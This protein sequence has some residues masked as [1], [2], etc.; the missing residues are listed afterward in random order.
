MKSLIAW[1]VKN[2]PAMNTVVISVIVV[3][4]LSMA[5]MRR[6]VFPD[7]DLEIILV[8]VP[9]P[10]A[11]P[12]EVEEGICLKVEE[13]VRS[14]EGVKRT[15]AIAQEGSGFVVLEMRPN[16]DVQKA[17]SEVRS[18]ID[19]IPSFPE[20]AEDPEVMQIALRTPAIRVA[21]IAPQTNDPGAD[22]RLRE[23]TER[24][25]NEL[26]LLPS[27]SQANLI[28]ARDYQIDVEIAEANLR[29]YG[30]SLQEVARRIRRENI[31][32]PAGTLKTDAS[33]VLLRGKDKQLKG[34]DIAKIPLVSQPNGAVLNVGDLGIVRDEFIDTTAI[35]RIDG[36][37]GL[38]ISI[39][40]TKS[41]D[42]VSMCNAV[43]KYCLES[44]LPG[45]YQLVAFR[46]TSV[47][48]FDRID[49]LLRNGCQG[50]IIVFIVLAMFME[51]RLAF[52][53]SAGI[54]VSIIGACGVLYFFGDTLN[55][56]SLYGFL[57][58]LGMV[59]DDAI[60]VGENIYARRKSGESPEQASIHGCAEVAPSVFSSVMTTVVCFM[61]LF[62]VSGVMGKFIAVMPLAIIATL[63]ISL[64][65][66]VFVL[67]VHLSEA[68]APPSGLWGWLHQ[69]CDDSLQW[70]I[71]TV[72][73]PMLRWLLAYPAVMICGSL[74]ILVFGLSL[75]TGGITPWNIFPKLDSATIE[76]RITYPDGTSAA[77]T[78]DACERLEA[79]I[80]EI[81]R[82]L[83][84]PGTSMIRLVHRLVGVQAAPGA[85]GPETRTSGAHVGSVTV[86]LLESS[87]RKVRSD[88]LLA[89][90]R[91]KMGQV[92]GADSIIFA[93]P[94]IGPGGKP[95]EF[96]LLAPLEKMKDLEAATEKVKQKL[97]TYK[98]VYDIAD[99]SRP[100]KY[101]F[102]I[103]VKD[104]A[105][106]LGIPLAD[107][108]ETVR[109]SF[110]G[111]EVMRLQ[112]GR[113]EVKLMVRY[114]PRERR[115]PA[116]L[117]SI[118]VRAQDGAERPLLELADVEVVRGYSEINRMNQMRTITITADID[119]RRG[120]SAQVTADLA[121]SFIPELLKEYPDLRIRWEGQ[122]QETNES[123]GSLMIGAAAAMLAMF[124]LLVLEFRSYFQP[125]LILSMLPFGVAGA[126]IGHAVMGLPVTMFS[127]FGIVALCGIVVNDSIVLVDFI[128]HRR[129]EGLPLLDALVDA[130]RRRFRPIMLTSITT[131]GGLFPIVIE[132]SLQAQVVIPMAVCICFGLL[133][134]TVL[135]LVQVPVLYLLSTWFFQLLGSEEYV[136]E[137]PPEEE[138][139]EADLEN[140]GV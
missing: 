95:I 66:S 129:N 114:P 90:W 59:V 74:L 84:P 22:L 11:S 72:Y 49:L 31:E 68:E 93:T 53:V 4:L 122:T 106:A 6:E 139:E 61:P 111:E 116:Q 8:T 127:L 83:A 105:Q 115:S 51:I 69:K 67:P 102:Q 63:L 64:A 126:I 97:E 70:F 136:K 119:E 60:V 85:L 134:S 26:L 1:A 57:M 118:R 117:E 101:E 131:I 43:K 81:D 48:V 73:E 128:N 82:E 123:L 77:S 91:E 88:T 75:F 79:A 92:A 32:L 100:G 104:S 40:R 45:G 50:L 17:I 113:H 52:W 36:K 80:R 54:P 23:M 86:E 110:Y 108:A 21:V 35:S 10:G 38:V 94:Q 103:K 30:L 24:V 99:D 112:R 135:A 42:L 34:E 2:A 47:D 19:R 37:P 46:D 7:F 18:E 76:A 71:D 96:K 109:A 55:M 121:A 56:L 132:T 120:N 12:T 15:V 62:F 44:N 29:K 65:E 98:G 138:V 25:R 16:S 41:E 9:Y 58:V 78:A 33:E 107:I 27:V 89:V 140:A 130:G 3:G 13:A 14:I 20:L 28:G 124:L 125:F 137:L 39:D 133:T 87:Q 5:N